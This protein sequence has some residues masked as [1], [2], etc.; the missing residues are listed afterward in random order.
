MENLIIKAESETNPEY[1]SC[2][3]SRPIKEHLSKGIINLDKTSGPT[4]HEIDSWV[5]IILDAQKTGHGGTLDPKVTGILPIGIDKATR[6]MQLLLAAEKEYICLMRLHREIDEPQ[7]R[8]IFSEFQGKIFQTPPLKSAVKREL[9][10]RNIYYANILEI[11]GQDVLFRIGCEAGT[12]IRKYCHDIGEALGIGAHM[13]EL[14]RTK[15]GSFKED[16]TVTT[17]HDLTDAYYYLK[18]DNDESL[19]RKCV[20]PMEKA[21]SHLPKVVVRDSAVD[22]ICHGA[23][24]AS[25]GILK[26]DENIKKG[27]TVAVETLKGELIAAGE[28]LETAE[29]IVESE[30]GIMVDTKKVFMEPSTYPKLWK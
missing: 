27:T 6:V 14:R 18:E 5:R 25:G 13:A 16:E 20:L 22:A 28:S 30:T 4:S 29:E 9:R 23:K 2:P 24:L 3:D 11:E 21:A 1:G 15:V 8:D 26:L 12:Y 7:I 19:I 17:L 10:V